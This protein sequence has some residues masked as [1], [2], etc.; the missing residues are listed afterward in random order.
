M[1]SFPVNLL[2]LTCLLNCF[3]SL[4]VVQTSER[5]FGH[6]FNGF[7]FLPI[8][9]TVVSMDQ[10]RYQHVHPQQFAL[11]LVFWAIWNANVQAFSNVSSV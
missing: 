8:V 4:H 1:L 7:C 11:V 9:Y 10:F 6:L 5:S 3:V 2:D